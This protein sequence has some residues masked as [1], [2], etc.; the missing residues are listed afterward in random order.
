MECRINEETIRHPSEIACY[1]R[2]LELVAATLLKEHEHAIAVSMHIR[3]TETAV[4][5]DVVIDRGQLFLQHFV[6]NC[7]R[8]EVEQRLTKKSDGSTVSDT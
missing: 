2:R 6:V 7:D 8:S 1:L 4:A 3:I 5:M